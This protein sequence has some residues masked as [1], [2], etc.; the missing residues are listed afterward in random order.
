MTQL[1]SVYLGLAILLYLGHS[2][3]RRRLILFSYLLATGMA[4]VGL[5]QGML[6]AIVGPFVLLFLARWVWG[7]VFDFRWVLVAVLA[8][9]FI[10]PVKNEFVYCR[11]GLIGRGVVRLRPGEAK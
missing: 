9:L 7:R 10:N 4:F 6:T 3:G 11:P 8:I 1:F 5:V 2:F